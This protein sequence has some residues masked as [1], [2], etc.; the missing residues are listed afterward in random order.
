MV[1]PIVAAEYYIENFK[2]I[3]GPFL[4]PYLLNLKLM[5]QL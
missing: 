4:G 5:L 3:S 1:D 2:H